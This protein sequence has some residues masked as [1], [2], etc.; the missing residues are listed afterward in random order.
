[1]KTLLQ[2]IASGIKAFFG[3]L[4]AFPKGM[5]SELTGEPSSKR[6]SAAYVLCI[7]ATPIIYTQKYVIIHA[8]DIGKAIDPSVNELLQFMGKTEL[9][10]ML[11]YVAAV[12]G[13]NLWQ[14]LK[15]ISNR[16]APSADNANTD[17]NGGNS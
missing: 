5:L 2:N 8:V 7:L 14:N 17:N 16:V 1:V 3:W 15:A 11:T 9:F 13:I 10:M 12:F 4:L 6:G